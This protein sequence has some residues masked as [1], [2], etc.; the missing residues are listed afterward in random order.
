MDITFDRMRLSTTPFSDLTFF[1]NTNYGKVKQDVDLKSS[2]DEFEPTK[3]ISDFFFFPI[4][5]INIKE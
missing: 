4:S 3:C 2:K 1:E 5:Y